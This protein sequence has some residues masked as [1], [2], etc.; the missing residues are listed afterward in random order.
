MLK[1][2]IH[3]FNEIISRL[4]E[5]A[6]AAAVTSVLESL[7]AGEYG[8]VN[9][10]GNE[11]QINSLK[12]LLH[13]LNAFAD[14]LIVLG[15]G[16]SDLGGRAIAQ[17]LGEKGSWD[18]IFAGDTTDPVSLEDVLKDVDWSKT[19]VNVVSKSGNTLETMTYY[20]IC[21]DRAQKA[22]GEH[23]N[24][25]FVFTTDADSGILHRESQQFDI[26]QIPVPDNVGG[27][28]SVLSAVG[29]FPALAL[30]ADA[31]NLLAGGRSAVEQF[32]QSK[33][34][35]IPAQI[36]LYQYAQLTLE[37]RDLAVMM[38]YSS[39]L[40]E[41]ARWFRQL[42]A[43]SLGK[44]GKGIMPILSYGPADQHSQL[45]F[46]TQGKD[47]ST[48]T[49]LRVADHG[50]HVRVPSSGIP[51]LE[52]LADVDMSDLINIQ[53]EGTREA[54]VDAGRPSVTIELPQ[55]DA[56]HLGEM[57]VTWELAVVILAKL[58]AVNAFDQPGVEDS[59]QK[60]LAR[61]ANLSKL[62]NDIY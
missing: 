9:I 50:V 41:F 4:D 51:E 47:T 43:E 32:T 37:N 53:E 42:W 28:F 6:K 21:K 45:Q 39:Q 34:Q 54:L 15:I 5:Q 20:A 3:N 60:T 18:V 22:L 27:R 24:D 1:L 19:I 57:F 29:L 30:G 33:M 49:F 23:W 55:V 25:H 62:K 38:P 46:Y 12:E 13:T 52:H 7:S 40:Y 58:L 36:A 14:T 59:K 31:E 10:L 2:T 16:G 11:K 26:A 56:L 44:D 8:F 48:F 17:A 35:S 61:L